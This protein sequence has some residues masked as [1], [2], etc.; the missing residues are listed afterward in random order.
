MQ[1]PMYALM[2]AGPLMIVLGFGYLIYETYFA[3]RPLH[4]GHGVEHA[5]HRGV[6]EKETDLNNNADGYAP[7]L[8][9]GKLPVLP[10][11]TP[12]AR[13]VSMKSERPSVKV[14]FGRGDC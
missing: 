1:I 3:V 10:T 6:V 9:G 2:F 13:S 11:V 7:N 12:V 8:H 5:Q 4:D 14:R